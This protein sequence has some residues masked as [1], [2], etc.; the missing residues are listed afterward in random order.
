[1]REKALFFFIAVLCFATVASVNIS[2][3]G[4][5]SVSITTDKPSYFGGETM[6]LSIT[7]VDSDNNPNDNYIDV[8]VYIINTSGYLNIYEQRGIQVKHTWN[9][10]IKIPDDANGTGYIY[11]LDTNTTNILGYKTFSVESGGVVSGALSLNPSIYT[12]SHTFVPGET[13]HIGVHD[14]IPSGNYTLKIML[15]TNV[16]YEQN[17]TVDLNGNFFLNY[18]IPESAP[19]SPRPDGTRY[20]VELYNGTQMVDRI[21]Y[22]VKLYSIYAATSRSAYIPGESVNVKFMVLYL[23]N[24]TPVGDE[25][26]GTWYVLTPDNTLLQNSTSFRASVGE[27]SFKFGNAADIGYYTVRI[28]YNDSTNA[29]PDRW[30]MYSVMVYCGN[31]GVYIFSPINGGYV[32]AGEIVTLSL[33]TFVAGNYD[34]DMGNLPEVNIRVNIRNG[35]FTGNFQTNYN[36]YMDFSWKVPET[37]AEGTN[38]E[39]NVTASKQDATISKSVVVSVYKSV[40]EGI[41]ANLQFDRESY[42]TGDN[43]SL[44]VVATYK[45]GSSGNFTYVYRVY[46]DAGGT[47][48]LTMSASQSPDFNY[49]PPL[50]FLGT[51]WYKV[52]VTDGAGNFTSATKSVSVEYAQILLSAEKTMYSPGE[53]LRFTYEILSNLM[54]NP[55]CIV[56]V[57]DWAGNPIMNKKV[58][59]GSFE[60]TIPKDPAE[61]YTIQIIAQ[62][63]GYTATKTLTIL[64][65]AGYDFKISISPSLY[66]TNVYR[67]GETIYISY[68]LTPRENTPRPQYIRISVSLYSINSNAK[69][70]ETRE[71]SGTITYTLPSGIGRGTYLLLVSCTVNQSFTGTI[72]GWTTISVQ[73]NPSVADLNVGGFRAMDITLLIIVMVL[74]LLMIIFFIFFQK[75]M[76]A[77]MLLHGSSQA[78]AQSQ[79]PNTQTQPSAPTPPPNQPPQ[80]P[81]TSY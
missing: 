74:L 60:I 81:K 11:V 80:P 31:L 10:N 6:H 61:S 59:N 39:F 55:E 50:N 51:L 69:V 43:I 7:G 36:G 47:N 37:L 19:D 24:N 54:K 26:F 38:I 15:G 42:L 20:S 18:T 63:S 21:C 14:C 57:K 64:K 2:A 5:S 44:H 77:H 12:R 58:E 13:L 79:T 75:K 46:R 68:A 1:M 65:Y 73:D 70:I 40:K 71:L 67:P 49:A 48:L 23:K 52:E 27:F 53:T 41:V 76:K 8:Y 3:S 28:Y 4:F 17:I 35:D 45:N 32:N 62:E 72:Y 25:L 16:K 78:P 9:E 29:E 66:T 30:D 34:R 56:S 33:K 22:D